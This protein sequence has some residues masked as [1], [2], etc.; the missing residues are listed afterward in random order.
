MDSP[1]KDSGDSS[2]DSPKEKLI[3]LA[4]LEEEAWEKAWSAWGIK[5]QELKASAHNL[6][7]N[8]HFQEI[9][10]GGRF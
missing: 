6:E 8:K 5:Q 10:N 7:V 9:N 1:E 2:D 4:V 3:A